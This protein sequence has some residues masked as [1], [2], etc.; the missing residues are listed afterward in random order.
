MNIPELKEAMEVVT[1]LLQLQIETEQ[2][3]GKPVNAL[4]TLLSTCQLL[5]DASDKMLPKKDE[6]KPTIDE[7]QAILDKGEGGKIYIKPDG[8]ITGGT[9][10]D[11]YAEGFREGSN[12]RREEDI[13]WLTKK[14]MGLGK[15]LTDRGNNYIDGR[16]TL[17]NFV[18]YAST[19]SSEE[20][21]TAII[22]SF[23]QEIEGEEK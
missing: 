20:L 13:L 17:Y 11:V 22:Q 21:A 6:P 2:W 7:L 10:E 3:R 1:T 23:G 9:P 15:V 5:C 18:G 4:N 16:S 8:S 14:L 19:M 12:Q